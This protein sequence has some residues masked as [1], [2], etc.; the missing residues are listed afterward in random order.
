MSGLGG[1]VAIICT[2]ID[3]IDRQ[4]LRRAG[5]IEIKGASTALALNLGGPGAVSAMA[6]FSHP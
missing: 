3:N 6:V 4:F 5:R 1:K 2:G